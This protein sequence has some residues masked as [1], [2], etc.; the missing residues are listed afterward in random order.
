MRCCCVELQDAQ[1]A[2]PGVELLTSADGKCFSRM[3]QT[4]DRAPAAE[5]AAA[6]IKAKKDLKAALQKSEE[7]AAKAA[8]VAA[9]E[10][11]AAARALQEVG[12]VAAGLRL[13]LG[14]RAAGMGAK[15]GMT[16]VAPLVVHAVRAP[17]VLGFRV[18]C[19]GFAPLHA[20]A[21][22]TLG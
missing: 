18:L 3:L 22:A 6:R 21:A 11:A 7:Q 14:L 20:H 19:L 17:A 10:R 12:G 4:A 8:A 5:A 15:H 13:R 1:G 2:L 9:A 16:Q